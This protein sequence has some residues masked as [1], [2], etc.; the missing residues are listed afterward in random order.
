MKVKGVE[1]SIG[2]DPEIFMGINGAFIS[3]H[4]KIPGD[5]LAP[6][7]VNNG[8]VQVDGMALEFNIDPAKNYKEF[9][10][11]LNVVQK[12]LKDMIG[13]YEFLNVS[14]VYFDELFTKNIPSHNL[15]LGC[16]PDYNGWTME[17]T[18]MPDQSKLMRTAGGHVHIGGINAKD[19]YEFHHFGECGRLARIL[20]ETVGVY[21][22]LWDKDDER[23]SMYG[24][25]G[26]FRPKKYGMEYRTLSNSW[27]FK[28]ST[29]K[30]VYDAV[31][32]ALK[33]FSDKDYQ[34][35]FSVREIINTSNRDSHFFNNNPYVKLIGV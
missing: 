18:P 12:I 7:K 29:V 3:A 31:V 35:D 25:A 9:S 33:K 17:E 14:S 2:A 23:R 24:Q 4:D 30:F 32:R 27:I 20:D 15:M 8:A 1:Y 21:S 13:D 22:I 6:H 19:P 26:C 16:Q 10:N 34:G 28:E 11:N 5:K